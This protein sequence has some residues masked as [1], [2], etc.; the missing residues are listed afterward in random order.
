MQLPDLCLLNIPLQIAGCNFIARSLLP[1][2]I[3]QYISFLYGLGRLRKYTGTA[4]MTSQWDCQGRSV[5]LTGK[6]KLI[7]VDFDNT[8]IDKS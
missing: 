1:P 7:V 8:C 6:K 4:I 3:P 2:P 5:D